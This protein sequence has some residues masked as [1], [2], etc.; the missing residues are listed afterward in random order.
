[1]AYKTAVSWAD[2]CVWELISLQW[3]TK[4]TDFI[5]FGWETDAGHLIALILS[6]IQETDT[7]NAKNI[8]CHFLSMSQTL[9]S[10]SPNVYFRVKGKEPES[11][12]DAGSFFISASVQACLQALV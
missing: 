1:M 9:L 6:V 4:P 7:L 8:N 10:S 12:H 3:S 11:H 2:I 5:L